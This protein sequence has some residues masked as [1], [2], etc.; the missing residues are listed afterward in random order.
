VYNT[1]DYWVLG[2]CQSSG[3]RNNTLFQKIDL[4]ASF[5]ERVGSVC[6]VGSSRK[7]TL[8]SVKVKVILRPTISRPV[9]PGVRHPSG[10]RDQFFSFSLWLFFSQSH[11][12]TDSQSVSQY[13][14]VPNSLWNLWPDSIF[15]L[16]VAMLSVRCPLWREVGSVF[17]QSLSSVFSPLS[18]IQYNLHCTCYVF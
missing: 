18:K 14:V 7:L 17:Y 4:F 6:F 2:P 13:V 9:R 3:V 15:C 5:G 1:K 11:V 16:K 10:T 8:F 12:T